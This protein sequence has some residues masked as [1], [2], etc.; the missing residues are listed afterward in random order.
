[1][2]GMDTFIHVVRRATFE[3]WLP[4]ALQCIAAL[5]HSSALGMGR[6]KAHLEQTSE[7]KSPVLKITWCL[8]FDPCR[9]RGSFFC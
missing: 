9:Y 4:M 6:W 5:P 7:Q 3:C 2:C 8:H 1:M